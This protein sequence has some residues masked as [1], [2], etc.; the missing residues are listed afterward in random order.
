MTKQ[1]WLDTSMEDQFAGEYDYFTGKL[2]DFVTR[3]KKRYGTMVYG[4]LLIGERH[5]RIC[6]RLAE[7]VE[8]LVFCDS[9]VQIYVDDDKLIHVDY[10]DHDGATYST[11]K[12]ISETAWNDVED[13]T[14][15][16]VEEL[17]LVEYYKKKGQLKPSKFWQAK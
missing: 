12:L 8:D 10:F 15:G 11:I 7:R 3:F 17:D 16:S 4:F 1:L 13:F 2:N 6:Y 5:G 14:G 9:T